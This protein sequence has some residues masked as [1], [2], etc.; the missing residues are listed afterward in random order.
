MSMLV[1]MGDRVKNYTTIHSDNQARGMRLALDVFKQ[2]SKGIKYDLIMLTRFDIQSKESVGIN[3]LLPSSA[4]SSRLQSHCP[5]AEEAAMHHC[6][7]KSSTDPHRYAN[8]ILH[9]MP[10]KYF[11]SFVP[12]LEHSTALIAN[13]ITTHRGIGATTLL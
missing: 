12:Y 5:S 6:G 3:D 2:H 9:I 7:G 1:L 11:S 8:D 10:A 4:S 13:I